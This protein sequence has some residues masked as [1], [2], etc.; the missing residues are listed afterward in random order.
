MC[1]GTCISV[2]SPQ[3]IP[4]EIGKLTSL[5]RLDL[6]LNGL[7]GYI[8]DEIF[9][10]SSLAELDVG[11]QLGFV[12]ISSLAKKEESGYQGG[13]EWNCTRSDGTLA[14]MG[15]SDGLQGQI[16]GSQSI[17]KLR[18]LNEIS[19]NSNSFSGVGNV[20]QWLCYETVC[21]F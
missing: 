4:S 12:S 8:P 7:S 3:T 14:Y 18:Y 9:E 21:F 2:Y 16:L 19:I 15:D 17:K 1:F 13:N 10:M 11:Y 5:Q 6:S 20:C